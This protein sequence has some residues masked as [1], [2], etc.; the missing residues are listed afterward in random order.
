MKQLSQ[1]SS[2]ITAGD[3]WGEES[4]KRNSTKKVQNQLKT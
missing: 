1:S 4:C 2:L 3:K